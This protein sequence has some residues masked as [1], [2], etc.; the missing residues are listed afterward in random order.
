MPKKER[1]R[2]EKKVLAGL[3]IKNKEEKMEKKGNK[4][5]GIRVEKEREKRR[6]K[7]RLRKKEMAEDE[8]KG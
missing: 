8:K 4:K 1:V 6:E 2:Q 7:R 5:I 3:K